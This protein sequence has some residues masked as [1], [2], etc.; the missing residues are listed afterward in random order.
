M[1]DP[2]EGHVAQFSDLAIKRAAELITKHAAA[3]AVMGVH[4]I[5][6]VFGGVGG[7]HR[8][9][10]HLD[11]IRTTCI[12]LEPEGVATAMR[13]Y[14]DHSSMVGDA[15]ATG[16]RDDD[17]D[18]GFTSPG[19]GNRFAD[20]YMGG[21]RCRR[22]GGTGSEMGPQSTS[23]GLDVSSCS[24][25]G[26][27]GKDKSKRYTYAISLGRRLSEG[28]GAAMQWGQAYRDLHVKAW[29][30]VYRI[31]RDLFILDIKDHQ[32][33]GAWQG[34]PGWHLEAA[35]SVGWDLVADEIYPVASMRHGAN[36]N[37]RS[38]HAYLYVFRKGSPHD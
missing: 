23:E 14:P 38:D 20:P 17:F 30:E 18:I 3:P 36:G 37:D 13:D 15:T 5:V 21:G 4:Q 25:C 31:T 27:S 6:D 11:N 28:N 33:Q 26:G 22:C 1:V 10:E 16:L 29:R 24:R 8:L 32:R 2:W 7:V 35:Q 34:V 19:F 12:E 9:H